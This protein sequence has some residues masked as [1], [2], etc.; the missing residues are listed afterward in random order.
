MH[1]FPIGTQA[2]LQAMSTEVYLYFYVAV[3][4]AG[5]GKESYIILGP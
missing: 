1:G 4:V 5:Q 2:G 3:L